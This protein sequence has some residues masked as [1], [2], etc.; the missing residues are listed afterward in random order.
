MSNEILDPNYWDL[1]ELFKQIYNVP[2]YQ[3]PYS[4]EKEQVN[5]LLEDLFSSYEEDKNSGY[6]IGNIIIY[7]KSEKIDGIINKYEI[8]DGQQ[9]ITTFALILLSLFCLS[10]KSGFN[11]SDKTVQEIKSCLWKYVK[12]KYI[13]EYQAVTLNSVEKLAFKDLYD[14]CFDVENEKFD[15]IQFCEKYPKKNRFE[16]R[17]FDNFIDIYNFLYRNL[18][19]LSN[20]EVLNFADYL[21]HFVQFIVI[22]SKGS[23]N[24]VFSMFESINSKGKRLDEIDL[25]KT[26]IFSQLNPTTYDKYLKIWG[27]LII[28]TDDNLYDYLYNFIKAYICFYRQNISIVNF[29]SICKKELLSFYHETSVQVALSKFL[30]DL[31]SK[32]KF[33]K[34]LNSTEEVYKLIRNT[35]LR[36]YY[37]IFTEIGYKH[38]KPLFLRTL[39]EYSEKKN[40]SG[41]DVVEI[42]V[43]TIKFMIEFL[44]ISAKDSKDVISMFSSIMNNTYLNESVS[45]EIVKNAIYVEIMK[46]GITIERLK[47]DL[48]SI[49]GYEQNKKLSVALLALYDSSVNENNQIKTSYDQAYLIL[50]NFSSSFSLDHLLVQT[51][52]LHSQDFKYFK[53]EENRLVL[54]DGA[55]FPKDIIA[56]MDFDVFTKMI[57]NK[58]GN[59]RIYYKDKNARRNNSSISLKEYPDFYS[60]SKIEKRSQDIVNLLFDEIFSFP[61]VEMS[62]IHVNQIKKEINKFPKMDELIQAGIIHIG[63]E[64]YITTDPKNSIAKL[65]DAR[66]VEYNNKKM[67]LNEWGRLVTGWKSICIYEYSARFGETETLQQKRKKLKK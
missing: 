55:D 45:K 17:V 31:N 44:T 54:K 40:L 63:D 9:R 48:L 3:R 36:Y 24:K 16:E 2:V 1:E 47:E 53:D 15:I 29:K 67:T 49:D 20:E 21:L 10:Y 65:L 46:Q 26:F 14:Y 7:D 38:P 27:N 58:I 52:D 19:G 30:D 57:L 18:C 12:R 5:V 60:Y 34:M 13:K 42:I 6:Y 50:K 56:G 59:L 61:K 8:I 51:P 22:Q 41:K 28:E 64:L 33:Y 66:H 62:K 11:D 35:K 4:W 39:I 43:E 25:I 23:E 32:V 37:Q